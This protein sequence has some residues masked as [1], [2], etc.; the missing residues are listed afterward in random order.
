MTSTYMRIIDDF[1]RTGQERA[2]RGTFLY[3][4]LLLLSPL[5]DWK[6]TEL[7]TVLIAQS[8]PYRRL[9]KKKLMTVLCIFS[10][11]KKYIF[12][13]YRIYIYIYI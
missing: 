3:F 12:Y 6:G 4:L 7:A 8:V 10:T 2:E 13:I 9:T 1:A 5:S 11:L